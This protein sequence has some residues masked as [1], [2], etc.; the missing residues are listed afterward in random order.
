MLSAGR[1]FEAW[2]K[3]WQVLCG[4]DLRRQD[5]LH[6]KKGDHLP[7]PGWQKITVMIYCKIQ[8]S[9]LGIDGPCLAACSLSSC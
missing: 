6:R 4:L 5:F 8:L 9:S 3:D 1:F 2:L 7:F